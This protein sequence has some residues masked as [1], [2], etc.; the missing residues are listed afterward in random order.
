MIF[1][2][3][4][5]SFSTAGLNYFSDEYFMAVTFLCTY[6]SVRSLGPVWQ[7]QAA[8]TRVQSGSII[9]WSFPVEPGQ[10]LPGPR[11]PSSPHG[12]TCLFS[13]VLDVIL[14]PAHPRLSHLLTSLTVWRMTVTQGKRLGIM[15]TARSSAGRISGINQISVLTYSLYKN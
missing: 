11:P 12:G 10:S 14:Q 9:Q 1:V 7:T 5:V 2:L 4:K 15:M 8:G 13:P 3:W 6:S